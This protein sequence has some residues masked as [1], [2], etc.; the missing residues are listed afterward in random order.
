MDDKTTDVPVLSQQ[1]CKVVRVYQKAIVEA[2]QRYSPHQ[3]DIV[4]EAFKRASLTHRNAVTT[5]V[6]RTLKTNDC[7]GRERKEIPKQDLER[8]VKFCLN[9]SFCRTKEIKKNV[10]PSWLQK[11]CKTLK[12]RVRS[13]C[14]KRTRRSNDKKPKDNMQKRERFE[15]VRRFRVSKQQKPKEK[16]ERSS[17]EKEQKN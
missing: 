11:C 12:P 3:M 8:N 7:D 6:K 5:A 4:S 13:R 16:N 14:H 1:D 9:T 17:K 15:E 10:L 2:Q